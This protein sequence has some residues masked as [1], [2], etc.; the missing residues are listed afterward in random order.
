MF[1]LAW[2]TE[3]GLY[4]CKTGSGD[5]SLCRTGHRYRDP[6]TMTFHD[7]YNKSFNVFWLTYSSHIQENYIGIKMFF[8]NKEIF[9]T[10]C[11]LQ[12][13]LAA[14]QRQDILLS[15]SV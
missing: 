5:P 3:T 1:P 7:I 14:K 12:P 15:E 10:T 11:T 8:W 4:S 13:Q 6:Q 2:V 9:L